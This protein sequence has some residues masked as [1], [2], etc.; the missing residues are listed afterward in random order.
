[1]KTSHPHIAKKLNDKYDIEEKVQYL[2]DNG[3]KFRE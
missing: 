3:I 1:M 2:K